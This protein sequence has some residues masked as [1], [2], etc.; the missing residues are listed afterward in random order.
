MTRAWGVLLAAASSCA[1]STDAFCS[2]SDG[3]R[4]VGA[5]DA[6]TKPQLDGAAQ[7]AEVHETYTSSVLRADPTYHRLSLTKRMPAAPWQSRSS[8]LRARTEST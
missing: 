1:T 2:G 6:L 5:E 7:K 4:L 8:N 3:Q